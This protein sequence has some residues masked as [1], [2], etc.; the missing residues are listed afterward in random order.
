MAEANQVRRINTPT[1]NAWILGE[2]VP[3]TLFRMC[4]P[5]EVV[6]GPASGTR[7]ILISLYALHQDREYHL[8]TDDGGGFIVAQSRLRAAEAGE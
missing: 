6:A 2:G 5:V 8:E 1:Q 7:G 3:G 4:Q